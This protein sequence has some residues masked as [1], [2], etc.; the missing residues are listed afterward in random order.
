MSR[1]EGF[2]AYSQLDDQDVRRLAAGADQNTDDLTRLEYRAPR[3][4][5]N[6]QLAEANRLTL[7]RYRTS[8]LPR[9]LQVPDSTLALLAAAE[10]LLKAGNVGDISAIPQLT[11]VAVLRDAGYFL[12][13][14]NNAPSTLPLELMRGK[15][16]LGRHSLVEAKQV[17]EAGLRLVNDSP[18]AME[19]LATVALL[20]GDL[21]EADKQF[22]QAMSQAP[23][24]A[25][26][27]QIMA[28]VESARQKW[29]Q[30]AD[31]QSRYMATFAKPPANEYVGLGVMLT[32]AGDLTRA[33]SVLS[34]GLELDP[35]SFI[36]RRTLAE[37][38]RRGSRWRCAVEHLEFVVRYDPMG[39]AN[40]YLLLAEAYLIF[41]DRESADEIIRKRTR[42]FPQNR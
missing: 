30:A 3:G 12:N 4:L 14:L 23:D 21:A 36:G 8:Y 6:Q 1:P 32:N 38:C 27:L 7:W 24:H 20:Q 25:P 22:R 28:R 31:W 39:N 2:V 19:A 9:S 10:T 37:I 15:S 40:D 13:A 11:K 16:N 33:E 34:R 42:L 41:G 26:A 17:Y 5:A 18:E 29:A 35:Y